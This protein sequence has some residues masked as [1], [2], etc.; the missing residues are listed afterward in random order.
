MS[1]FLPRSID[2]SCFP[3]QVL[4]LRNHGLVSVGESVEE[5]FYY[6]HNLVVACEIQVSGGPS[7]QSAVYLGVSVDFCYMFC[8]NE[9][10]SNVFAKDKRID[11]EIDQARCHF[12]DL[13]WQMI[14]GL[15]TS[16][17]LNFSNT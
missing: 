7:I 9:S 3:P 6:I 17:F 2:L 12:T 10:L 1:V 15:F 16:N 13:S 4:I 5:A 8:K 14:T 11:L